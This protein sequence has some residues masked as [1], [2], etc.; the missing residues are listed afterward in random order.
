MVPLDRMQSHDH[1]KLQGG[2]ECDLAVSPKGRRNG[3]LNSE[4][5]SVMVRS[6]GW[7][8]E[9]IRCCYKTPENAGLVTTN[10]FIQCIAKFARNYGKF[11]RVRND[12]RT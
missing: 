7:G 11:P 4:I 6:S 12:T 9:G 10:F 1:T 2:C 5:C 3:L 8:K